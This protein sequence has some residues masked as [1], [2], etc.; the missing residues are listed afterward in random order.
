MGRRAGKG[1]GGQGGYSKVGKQ[2]SKGEVVVG[3]RR[4]WRDPATGDRKNGTR[5]T[6]SLPR[7]TFARRYRHNSLCT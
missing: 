7:P 5:T 4:V 3:N 1:G 6:D 2:I